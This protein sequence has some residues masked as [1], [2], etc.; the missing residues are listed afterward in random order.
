[1][2]AESHAPGDWSFKKVETL[3]IVKY[4]LIKEVNELE[5]GE[6]EAKKIATGCC[7]PFAARHL[8]HLFEDGL[9]LAGIQTIVASRIIG[10]F[11]PA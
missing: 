11:W 1:M 5:I 7:Q 4:G 8:P 3:S 2:S 10:L 9:Q 6:R